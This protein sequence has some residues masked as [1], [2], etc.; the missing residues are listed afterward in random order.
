MKTV[1]EAVFCLNWEQMCKLFDLWQENV[2][3][4][5]FHDIFAYF[6]ICQD[7]VGD[8]LLYSRISLTA[9]VARRPSRA[10]PTNPCL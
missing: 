4:C 6:M 1:P 8:L 5:M 10:D 7:I 9:K 3:S 2:S